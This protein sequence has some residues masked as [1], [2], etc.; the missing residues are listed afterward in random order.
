MILNQKL[1]ERHNLKSGLHLALG[2]GIIL[3]LHTVNTKMVSGPS[4]VFTQIHCW[5]TTAMIVAL[6]LYNLSDGHLWAPLKRTNSSTDLSKL[7]RFSDILFVSALCFYMIN[8]ITSALVFGGFFRSDAS[9]DLFEGI[10]ALAYHLAKISLFTIFLNRLTLS[11]SGS[12]Y[13]YSNKF[14]KFPLYLLLFCYLLFV[15]IGDFLLIDAYYDD[16]NINC[17]RYPVLWGV[18]LTLFFDLFFSISYAILFTLPLIKLSKIEAAANIEK[19]KRL[20]FRQRSINLHS[21]TSAKVITKQCIKK[22]PKSKHTAIKKTE[23]PLQTQIQPQIQI[24]IQETESPE[25]PASVPIAKTTLHNPAQSLSSVSQETRDRD[26]SQHVNNNGDNYN[27]DS[28]RKNPTLGA[29]NSLSAVM[30]HSNLTSNANMNMTLTA[31]D[32]TTPTPITATTPT[33]DASHGIVGFGTY[34]GSSDDGDGDGGCNDHDVDV[35]VVENGNYNAYGARIRNGSGKNIV[36][37]S[38]GSY[39]DSS[40]GGMMKG[41]MKRNLVL[42]GIT[43]S[44]SIIML[45]IAIFFFGVFDRNDL[46]LTSVVIMFVNIDNV[47]NCCCLLL[48]KGKHQHIYY[49]LCKYICCG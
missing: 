40:D 47:I 22:T 3:F 36:N 43:I 8:I 5:G 20:N 19:N 25:N 38:Y 34:F 4:N 37:S 28:P 6:L 1:I 21:R 26:S 24:Q 18:A 9:C 15:L 48:M 30:I 49:K 29:V 17:N 13:D 32:S 7:K 27:D 39:S 11:F 46:F 31:V 44:S 16:I 14:L 12:S 42:I 45:T 23:S 10:N 2:I 33:G 35:D 41:L